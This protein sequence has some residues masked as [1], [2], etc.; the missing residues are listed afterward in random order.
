[1]NSAMLR[2]GDARAPP[3]EGWKEEELQRG[4]AHVTPLVVGM[5]KVAPVLKAAQALGHYQGGHARHVAKDPVE[6]EKEETDIR[7]NFMRPQHLY[8]AAYGRT[9]GYKSTKTG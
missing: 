5:A 8:P 4:L 7:L 6:E 2:E 1:M 3:K 9:V